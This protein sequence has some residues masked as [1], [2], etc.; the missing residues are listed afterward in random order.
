MF[1]TTAETDG[2]VGADSFKTTDS[3]KA[4]VLLWF[5]IGYFW[6]RF[7]CCRNFMHYVNVSVLRH[8]V[9]TKDQCFDLNYHKFS[10]K[11]YVLDV[12]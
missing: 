4:V 3:S 5:S 10:I 8:K 1:L 12:Y 7:R 2:E 9:F 6:S 11:S